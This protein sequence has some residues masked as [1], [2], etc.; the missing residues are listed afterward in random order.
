MA[1]GFVLIKTAPGMEKKVYINLASKKLASNMFVVFGEYDIVA[2]VKARDFHSMGQLIVEKIRT[3]PGVEETMTL[4]ET[5]IAE[6][7]RTI[8]SQGRRR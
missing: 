6:L 2:V 8:S 3:I 7:P 5:K 4:A 1:M